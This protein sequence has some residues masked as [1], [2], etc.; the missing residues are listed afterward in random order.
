MSNNNHSTPLELPL[1]ALTEL[2]S[3]SLSGL[4]PLRKFWKGMLIG[5]QGETC[6][7]LYIISRG[8][9]LL[10]L[11]QAADSN[12]PL[13]LLG[14]GEVFGEGSLRPERRWLVTARAVTDGTVHVLPAVHLPRLC[15]YYP[16]LTSYI[17][18]LL[19][20]RL[21][22]A[23]QRVGLVKGN[24]GR[25]RLLGLLCV[26][27]RHHGSE[28]GE[29]SR[30]SVYLTQAELGEMVGLARETIARIFADLTE[31]GLVRRSGRHTLW[32]HASLLAAS[33]AHEPSSPH[34]P[35]E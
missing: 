2:N 8:Q 1:Q 11:D 3:G 24:S 34:A 28:E 10:S 26:F 17:I 23:H 31:E 7:Q 35:I 20:G 13:Y 14:A 32:L 22:R 21:E 30:L 33:A 4:A 15:Q 19:S 29:W 27:A 18:A 5:R 25:E 12:D 9:V 6:D 16:E